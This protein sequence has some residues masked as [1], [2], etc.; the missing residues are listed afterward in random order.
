MTTWY[1]TGQYKPLIEP[2]EVI[3]ETE[4][5]VVIS[6][7]EWGKKVERKD[8]KISQFHRYWKTWEE[9]RDFLL[10]RA[11]REVDS[12]RFQLNQKVGRLGNIKGLKPPV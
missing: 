12:A 8:A 5:Y 7:D 1:R 2:V 11:E 10:E 4:K 9:A 3:R 6:I